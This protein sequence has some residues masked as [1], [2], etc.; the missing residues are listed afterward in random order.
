MSTTNRVL[1]IASVVVFFAI[2]IYGGATHDLRAGWLWAVLGCI[3][4]IVQGLR[5]RRGVPSVVAIYWSGMPGTGLFRS[6]PLL[7][8]PFAP[9]FVA[10]LILAGLVVT[11]SDLTAWPH[12]ARS[13]AVWGSFA[14]LFGVMGLALVASYAPPRWLL[15]DWLKE[16]GARSPRPKR[17]WFDYATLIG[18]LLFVG[19]GAFAV[20][21]A[22]L[23]T[24]GV[25]GL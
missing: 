6:A 2:G 24:Q 16:A 20:Y 22:I 23:G 7:A 5:F 12:W 1:V 14:Y 4:F 18:G 10:W 3:V 8:I 19:S 15:P 25:R 21:A 11:G 13:I 9:L 17:N